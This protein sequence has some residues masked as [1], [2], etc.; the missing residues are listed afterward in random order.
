VSRKRSQEILETVK[1]LKALPIPPDKLFTMVARRFIGVHEENS[2]NDGIMVR[3]FQRVVGEAV[4]EPWCLSFVQGC[5]MATEVFS[6]TKA[7][8]PALEHC[9]M[10]AREAHAKN[11]E[12]P[13]PRIGCVVLW[14]KEGSDQG[15]A[16]IVID[17]LRTGGRAEITTVE[18]NTGDED[19]RDGDGVYMKIRLRGE[20]PGFEKPRFFDPDFRYPLPKRPPL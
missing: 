11:I 19:Q 2:N 5:I 17:I 9:Q 14:K 4:K 1:D 8:F 6:N 18:G 20:I 10:A 7:T 3:A 15:H 16:G 12:L 13:R